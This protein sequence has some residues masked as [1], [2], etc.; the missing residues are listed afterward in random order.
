VADELLGWFDSVPEIV[1]QRTEVEPL[2]DVWHAMFRFGLRG[3]TPQCVVEQHWYCTV[4]DGQVTGLRLI[5]SGYRPVA[6]EPSPARTIDALGDGCATLTPR[7][8]AALRDLAHGEV[9]SVLTDDPAAADDLGAWS[10]LTGHA[11]VAT[12]A[13]PHG[14][15]FY[16][17]HA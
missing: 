3:L 2:A 5:C 10:R 9:L 11:I 16:L 8:A 4:D 14:V 12:T 6:A 13:E 7:I 1:V 15:R 17:R